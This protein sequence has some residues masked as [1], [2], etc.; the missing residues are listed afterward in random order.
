MGLSY[1]ASDLSVRGPLRGVVSGDEPAGTIP[2]QILDGACWASNL[3]VCSR[4]CFSCSM[5]QA[6]ISK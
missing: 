5:Q 1:D 4:S 2:R 6:T 3:F